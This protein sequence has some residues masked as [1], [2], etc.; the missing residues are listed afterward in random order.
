MINNRLIYSTLVII[1]SS[2]IIYHKFNW[3]IIIVIIFGELFLLGSFLSLIKKYK[4]WRERRIRERPQ[5][6]LTNLERN[7]NNHNIIHLKED[8][9]ICLEELEGAIKLKCG[10]IYHRHC[11]NQMIEYSIHLCP[12]CRQEMV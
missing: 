2:F 12:L 3:S 11:I 1:G 8:C 7:L 9:I 5:R 4:Q 10:H 6:V